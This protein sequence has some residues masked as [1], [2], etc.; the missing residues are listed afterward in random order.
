[1]GATQMFKGLLERLHEH[2]GQAKWTLRVLILLFFPLQAAAA[3]AADLPMGWGHCNLET[4]I[5]DGVC[6]LQQSNGGPK[7]LRCTRSSVL[8]I[9]KDGELC[10][11]GCELRFHVSEKK[12][13]IAY[14]RA[15]A[16]TIHSA[17]GHQ[18]TEQKFNPK[19]YPDNKQRNEQQITFD[20]QQP[21]PCTGQEEV[22]VTY[23]LELEMK[24]N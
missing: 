16:L 10:A 7:I 17:S 15:F 13:P 2:R 1:M 9:K 24:R 19:L 8:P 20:V 23:T 21:G 22:G 12:P 3:F 11:R 18:F 4:P 6:T 5:E 14:V